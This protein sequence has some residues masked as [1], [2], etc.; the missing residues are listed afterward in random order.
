MLSDLTKAKLSVV[1]RISDSA[2]LCEI[3]DFAGFANIWFARQGEFHSAVS[4]F[5]NSV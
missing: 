4:F 3:R 5:L 2:R 1:C